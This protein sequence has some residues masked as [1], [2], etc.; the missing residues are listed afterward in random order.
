MS[1]LFTFPGQ[2][3]Q[4]PGLLHRL[5]PHP[6]VASTLQQASAVLG[7]DVFELDSAPALQSTIAVQLCLLIAGVASAR[8]LATQ[9]YRPDMVAGLSIGAYPAT[10]VA[11]TLEFVDALRLVELRGRLMETAY[12]NGYGMTAV[13][14]LD[15]YQLEPLLEQARAEGHAAY[16]A[17]INGDK[18]LVVAGSD[19][20]LQRVVELAHTAGALK[21]KRL[22]MSVPSHCPLLDD[23][24][25]QMRQAFS[26]VTVRRPQLAY[27]SANAARV[28]Y[29]PASIAD[30]LANNMAR[31]VLWHDAS[32]LAYERGA[33]LAL[34]MPPG[35][36]LTGML[37]KV[38]TEGRTIAMADTRLDTVNMLIERE[39]DGEHRPPV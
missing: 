6:A 14:G 30:D 18:Q 39:H 15:R 4:S 23:A 26:T 10:V 22:A 35:N 20:G 31:M 12:P 25:A 34:E 17:N 11:G 7:R 24:A 16:L 9:G 37:R 27:I 3:A 29:D 38:F 21:S 33:R 28:L 5:G 32:L 19:R 8:V 2:D 36:V 1:V 13:L